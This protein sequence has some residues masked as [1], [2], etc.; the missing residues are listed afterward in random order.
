[1]R[2]KRN[3][4]HSGDIYVLGNVHLQSVDEELEELEVLELR[5]KCLESCQQ[6]HASDQRSKSEDAAFSVYF[7]GSRI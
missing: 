4:R 5:R 2:C 6:R 3:V 1:M 7:L